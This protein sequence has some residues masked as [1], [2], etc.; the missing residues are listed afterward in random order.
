MPVK[1]LG[2]DGTNEVWPVCG[3]VSVAIVP[4]WLAGAYIPTL[5]ERGHSYSTLLY[6][7]HP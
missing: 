7:T 3:I 4:L 5:Y 2:I 1:S 6:Y